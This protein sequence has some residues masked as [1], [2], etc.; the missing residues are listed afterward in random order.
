MRSERKLTTS[1]DCVY[2]LLFQRLARPVLAVSL[3]GIVALLGCSGGSGGQQKSPAITTPEAVLALSQ[4]VTRDAD[5]ITPMDAGAVIPGLTLEEASQFAAGLAQFTKVEGSE[6]GLGPVFNG[7]SCGECHL[8]G[9][10]GGAA[11]DQTV[12]VV[13][14][15][16]AMVNGTYTDLPEKGGPVMER[17]SLIEMDPACPVSPEVVPPEATFV[18]HRTTTPLFGTGLIEGVPEAT[19]RRLADPDDLDHDGISGRLNMVLNPETGKVEVGRFGWKAQISSLSVFS[20]DA[21]LNEMGITTPLFPTELLPQGQTIDGMD[22]VPEPED[23][24]TD[25]LHFTHFMRWLAPPPPTPANVSESGKRGKLVFQQVGCVSCHVPELATG[26]NTTKALSLKR[27]ALYSDLLLHDMGDGLADGIRQGEATGS[28][29]RT[30]PLWGLHLRKFLLHDGRA[31]SVPEAISLHG[32]EATNVMNRYGKLS[33]RDHDD[34]L[35]F[36]ESL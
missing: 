2:P 17:R 15:F 10:I 19:L 21:Y 18:S 7:R 6:E 36:V 27:F 25:T 9:G 8:Q 31:T 3:T 4:E 12:S 29:F 1:W 13:T 30:A 32:G 14:R 20:A 33:A 22:T 24:G 5:T 35:T 34:L 11:F 26:E 16:G 28:E 23:D